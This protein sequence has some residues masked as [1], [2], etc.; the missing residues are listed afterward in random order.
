VL[1]GLDQVDPELLPPGLD[2]IAAAL[3][4]DALLRHKNHVREPV[5]QRVG[6]CS[7]QPGDAVPSVAQCHRRRE[8]KFGALLRLRRALL[9]LAAAQRLRA[10]SAQVAHV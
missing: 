6:G 5:T 8:F 7:V 1:R 9:S 2:N 10:S 4:H 3:K